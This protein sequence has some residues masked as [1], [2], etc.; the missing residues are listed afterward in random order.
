MN[1]IFFVTIAFLLNFYSLILPSPNYGDVQELVDN[2]DKGDLCV[3]ADLVLDLNKQA[4][5]EGMESKII[6]IK[7]RENYHTVLLFN[8]TDQGELCIDLTRSKQIY[9]RVD[10]LNRYGEVK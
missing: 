2:Y 4:V 10:I 9:S 5:N 3:C 8:T 7:L 1:V 6:L